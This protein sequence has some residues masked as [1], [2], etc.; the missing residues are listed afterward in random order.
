LE[1][2]A[3]IKR[4]LD[5]TPFGQ[6]GEE[7]TAGEI[8]TEDSVI[9]TDSSGVCSCCNTHVLSFGYSKKTNANEGYPLQISFGC[10]SR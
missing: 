7:V 10:L 6:Q 3:N 9:S 1:K 8:S 4:V 5:V 2:N